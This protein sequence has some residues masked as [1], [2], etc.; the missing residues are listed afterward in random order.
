MDYKSHYDRLILRARERVLE[1][2]SERHHVVPRCMGGTDLPDNLV[3]L[4]AEEHYLTHQLLCKIH[5][6][7]G[8]LVHA[9]VLMST[10]CGTNKAYGWLKR[11]HI[12]QLAE[13]ML[14]NTHTL[15][16]H[17]T[18]ESKAKI[19]A[20]HLGA[21]R[22]P[23]TRAKLRAAAMG[24]TRGLGKKLPPFTEEHRAKMRS[25][26]VGAKLSEEHR[27]KIGAAHRGK[28]WPGR[29]LSQEHKDRVGAAHRGMKRTIET[30]ARISAGLKAAWARRKANAMN[31]AS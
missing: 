27:A 8:R 26:K 6:H 20:R 7:N 3:A 1:G 22:P 17:H 28:K 13:N 29:V 4:T 18:D 31:G 15:G 2:Y 21:K 24:N 19:S 10:R 12:A 11:R 16:Y 14:G 30:A 9:A 5:P 25:A 23:E